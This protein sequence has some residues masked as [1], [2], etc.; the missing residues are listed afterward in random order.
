M[1]LRSQYVARSHAVVSS[2]PTGAWTHEPSGS[3]PNAMALAMAK[4]PA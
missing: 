3:V 2:S 1:I 4:S